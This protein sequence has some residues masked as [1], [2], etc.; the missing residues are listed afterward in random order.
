MRNSRC[1]VH[2]ARVS[3]WHSFNGDL[4]I[5]QCVTCFLEFSILLLDS[6]KALQSHVAS[7]R[8]IASIVSDSLALSHLSYTGSLE[9][10][11]NLALSD[12]AQCCDH[13]Q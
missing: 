1:L 3:T 8:N 6:R 5:V 13:L 4:D 11:E 12:S 9:L 7:E 2:R 10:H